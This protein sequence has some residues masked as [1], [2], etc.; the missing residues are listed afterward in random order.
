LHLGAI[1][2]RTIYALILAVLLTIA[3]VTQNVGDGKIARAATNP[4]KFKTVKLKGADGGTE[5][6]IATGRWN[7]RWVATNEAGSGEMIIYKSKDGVTWT[8]TKVDPAGQEIATIDVD[9]VR[10][11][12]KR[13]IASELDFE[14]INFRTSYSDDGGKTWTESQGAT[15]GDTDRQWLAAGR[16]DPETHE[17]PVY[18]MF[19]NLVSG[20]GNHNMYVQT[21]HDGG[22]TFGEPVP[23]TL[24]GTEEYNDLQCSDSGGP[25]S[26]MVN[27][28]TG[29]IYA[30]WGTRHSAVGGC[31]AQPPEVNVVGATRVWVATSM[32]GSLGSWTTSLA[33]DRSDSGHVVGMQLS[34]G[35]LDNKG[36]VYVAFPESPNP[37][38]NYDGASINYTWAP[39]DLSK[40]SKPVTVAPQGGPGNVLAHIV[41]GA[42]G[43]IDLAWFKG[44]SQGKGKKPAWYAT[45]AQTLNGL[46]AS[47]TIKRKKVSPVP[48]YTGT[49]SE[50]MG[51]CG[52]P[53]GGFTCNRSTDV[54]GIDLDLK[55]RLMITWPTV[56]N[57][58]PG[59]AA[60]TYV[61]T[62]TGGPTVCKSRQI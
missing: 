26:L 33:V 17:L 46:S 41:V 39:A 20:T 1:E 50:L 59:A 40:W 19:H 24:P 34:P 2:R 52:D 32:D 3:L 4:L 49:A 25:S 21:S 48:T 30:V 36:N 7:W 54:W 61:T 8:R 57:E 10:T 28:T 58:A 35:A 23:I 43:K 27:K 60:G 42:P 9:I 38:P 18:L 11:H 29:Q 15:L 44:A 16:E 45:I 47:P 37:Y 13:S 56:A 6:R 5:P 31:G 62:Q 51:A 12:T 53:G 14:G 22:E 55:C